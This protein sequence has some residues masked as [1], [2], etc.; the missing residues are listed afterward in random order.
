[1]LNYFA[2]CNGGKIEKIKAYKLM[3]LSDRY[4]LR[5]YG[6]MISD[7][8]YYAMPHGSVP[9]TAKDML[10]GNVIVNIN[11]NE[12][13]SIINNNNYKT[14]KEP[15]LKVF[16]QT[17]RDTL[18]LIFDKYSG[19]SYKELS[20]VSHQFPEWVRF[21]D[22]IKNPKNKSSH[23]IRVIDFFEN[24]DDES[25]LFVDDD[26]LIEITKQLYSEMIQ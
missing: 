22:E 10:D 21:E 8:T 9:S 20:E 1:M 4:H 6:R 3:W 14:I 13:I 16:S 19:L 11:P 26:E 23:K 12:Y 25:G 24:V 2:E 17:D 18:S 5:Q 15:K 7:D